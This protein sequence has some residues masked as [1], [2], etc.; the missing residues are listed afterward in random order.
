M[1]TVRQLMKQGKKD[2]SLYM[3]RPHYQ[4]HT[5]VSKKTS[6]TSASPVGK[7]IIGKDENGKHTTQQYKCKRTKDPKKGGKSGRAGINRTVYIRYYGKKDKDAEVQVS[8]T[9]EFFKFYC[10]MALTHEGSSQERHSNG[11]SPVKTN[12]SE[13][14][15]ICKHI[16]VALLHKFG[17]SGG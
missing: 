13:L 17:E 12:S 4:H 6:R 10:E 15:Y 7:E 3:P 16:Y 8:C 1:Y 2:I 11:N 9:C 14:P 5:N